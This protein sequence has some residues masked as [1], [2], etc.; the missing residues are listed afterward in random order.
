M[1]GLFSKQKKVKATPVPAPVPSPEV[2]EETGEEAMK[3]ALKRGGRGKT[4]LTGNLVPMSTGKK[5]TLG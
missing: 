5:T 1:G 3:K 2:S 4:I